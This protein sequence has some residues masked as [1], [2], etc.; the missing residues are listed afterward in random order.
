MVKGNGSGD[1]YLFDRKAVWGLYRK[2]RCCVDYLCGGFGRDGFLP[3]PIDDIGIF[4]ICFFCDY[5]GP[6]QTSQKIPGGVCS[7]P[8][9]WVCG[10]MFHMTWIKRGS[11]TVEGTVV[12]S[13]ICLI[14]GLTI[15]LGFYG[16]DRSVMQSVAD[17]LA[18]YGCQWSGRYLQPSI[19]EV[20]YE[21]MKQG[22]SMDIYD[23]ENRGY[24]LLQD[25]MFCAEINGIT[26]SKSLLGREVQVDILSN[27]KI[28]GWEIPCKVS[29]VVFLSDDLPRR[30]NPDQGEE[31]NE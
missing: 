20:D 21:A 6:R 7:V 26:V 17:E 15:L 24:R 9:D 19:R 28:M 5:D 18:M 10:G 2:W 4:Y 25:K 8:D 14:I 31:A 29:G 12:I 1:V 16:H 23:I 13:L 30:K 22:K 3:A 27:F 11:Y